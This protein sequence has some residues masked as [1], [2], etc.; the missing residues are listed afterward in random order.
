LPS[1]Q[2]ERR[3]VD[4]FVSEVLRFIEFL[5]SCEGFRIL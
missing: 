2:K 4:E 3:F 1:G 5:H